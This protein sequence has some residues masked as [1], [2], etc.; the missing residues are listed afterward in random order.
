MI[1]GKF[2]LDSLV[3]SGMVRSRRRVL[4]ML[5]G[6]IIGSISGCGGVNNT[7]VTPGDIQIT[8]TAPDSSPS[9]SPTPKNW[10]VNPIE[11]DK[12]IGTF[13]FQRFF[14]PDGHS[15]RRGDD[16]PGWLNYTVGEPEL[17]EYRSRNPDV[18]NQHIKWAVDHGITW[19]II[20]GTQPRSVMERSIRN[21]ILQ[22]ELADEI[23]FSIFQGLPLRYRDEN[24]QFDFD[25]VE[26]Q[27]VLRKWMAYWAE[28]YF[29]HPNYQRIDDR[30]V[31]YYYDMDVARGDMQGAFEQ[32]VNAIPY[33]PYLIGDAYFAVSPSNPLGPPSIRKLAQTFDAVYDYQIFPSLPKEGFVD[34][35]MERYRTW[36]LAAEYHDVD[37]I[38]T[39]IPGFNNDQWVEAKDLPNLPRDPERFREMCDR[40]LD[41]I[42]SEID[43]IFIN[44]F[45]EWPEYTTIEPGERYGT[46]YL[47]IVAEELA[48]GD[49]SYYPVSK[50][51]PL[52]FRFN[53]TVSPVDSNPESEDTRDL[54]LMLDLLRFESTDGSQT[55]YDVGNADHSAVFTEGAYNRVQQESGNPTSWRWLG[56][57]PPRTTILIEEAVRPL[58]R[59]IIRGKPSVESIQ[60]EVIFQNENVGQLSFEDTS[61][62]TSSLTI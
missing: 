26:V 43:T 25:D 23:S 16:K 5:G 36:R 28:Q 32:A 44:T 59:I 50:Y 53:K 60:A 62:Q 1:T 37:F 58:E 34:K 22:A 4:G 56:G 11:H 18:I 52:E 24:N 12:R 14:G 47:E 46:T 54:A 10:A 39:V 38:P 21:H 2:I 13:Y 35:A 30:P 48:Q 15:F 29:D 61:I 33:D 57:D 45:N 31:L 40:A 9:N 49:P 6:G 27:D 3:S 7:T 51:L 8:T 55:T 17:G 41:F 42:D 19:F 20:P